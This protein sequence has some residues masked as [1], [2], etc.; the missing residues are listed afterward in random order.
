MV[1]RERDPLTEIHNPFA[2]FEPAPKLGRVHGFGNAEV[3]RARALGV[4]RAHVGVIR[5]VRAQV[6]DQLLDEVL[7][8]GIRQGVVYVQLL[9][10][11]GGPGPQ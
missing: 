10:D 11:S 4:D 2:G 5:R 8:I 3:R 1:G 7:L 9:T 6:R